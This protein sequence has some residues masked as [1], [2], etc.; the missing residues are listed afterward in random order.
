V[1]PIGP[2]IMARIIHPIMAIGFPKLKCFKS[3]FEIEFQ[4]Y[5][6]LPEQPELLRSTNALSVDFASDVDKIHSGLLYLR[7]PGNLKTPYIFVFNIFN[8]RSNGAVT[9]N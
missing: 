4:I 2:T 7:Q 1:D 9:T 5:L 8:F 6:P 3:S